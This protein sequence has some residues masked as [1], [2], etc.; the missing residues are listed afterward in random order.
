[1]NL[2]REVTTPS[3]PRFHYLGMVGLILRAVVKVKQD[4]ACKALD[5]VPD[6]REGIKYSV[7]INKKQKRHGQRH[8][9]VAVHGVVAK[10]PEVM[11]CEL[12]REVSQEIRQSG[13]W[14]HVD[15]DVGNRCRFLLSSI[16]SI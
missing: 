15:E 16:I 3:E 4:D 12:Y 9:D 8:G 14:D 11:D 10:L 2:C 5:T 7:V 6:A 13:R 1:M